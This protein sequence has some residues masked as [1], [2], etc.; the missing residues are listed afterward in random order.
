MIKD[1]S[2]LL[3]LVLLCTPMK[4]H[5]KDIKVSGGDNPYGGGY[6]RMKTPTQTDSDKNNLPEQYIQRKPETIKSTTHNLNEEGDVT[7]QN[8]V[9]GHYYSVTDP[10]ACI[11]KYGQKFVTPDQVSY[12]IAF[13]TCQ[14][15]KENKKQA[16]Q[17]AEASETAEK[18]IEAEAKETE[19]KDSS[20][21]IKDDIKNNKP[22]EKGF[23]Q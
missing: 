12:E 11:R 7:L 4:A 8:T 23:N 17:V 9:D 2:K 22:I 16:D 14:E 3:I 18:K 13:Q 15:L 21:I 1:I 5:A 19:N 20:A 6:I 10:Y